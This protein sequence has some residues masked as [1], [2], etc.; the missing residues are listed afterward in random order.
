M[1][2]PSIETLCVHLN[3][4]GQSLTITFPGGAEI[5]PQV[6]SAG[7]AAPLE[8]ARQL[9]AQA[10]AAMAPLIP[11]FNIVD[12]I[13]ALVEALKAVP[14]A[15]SNLDPGKVAEV[16]PD[17]RTKAS[18]LLP[19]APQVSVPLLVAGLLDAVVAYLDGIAEQLRG[20]MDQQRRTQHA[21]LRAAEL[22]NDSLA[23]VAA[24]SQS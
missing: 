21:A 6:P 24:C 18:R 17:V 8:V 4:T 23:K 15:I 19:L 7:F 2:L 22:G 10:N 9:L 13:L 5:S 14:D 1:P 20:M 11:I 12:A 3:V 16:I